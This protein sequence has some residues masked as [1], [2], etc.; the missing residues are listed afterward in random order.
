MAIQL[1]NL[2][3]YANDGTGDDLRSAFEK[4]NSNFAEIDS[5]TA[6]NGT[7]LGSGT[8]IFAGKISDPNF[9]SLLSFKSLQSGANIQLTSNGTTVTIASASP[10]TGD[11]TG[12]AA[13]V[14]S[15]SNH[16]ISD[17]SDVSSSTPV[18]GQA[19]VFTGSVWAP[20]NV[21]GGGGGGL[22]F[23]SFTSP[24]DFTLDLGYY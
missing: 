19:L 22:D 5:L 1:V 14:Q 9:G 3:T 23:G 12:S 16:T 24:S 20:G 17:L 7:N 11:V 8:V 6:S 18:T 10:F 4:I 21:S 2:G 15:I 13:T